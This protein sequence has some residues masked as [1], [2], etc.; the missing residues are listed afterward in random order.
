MKGPDTRSEEFL[1][2]NEELTVRLLDDH[3]EWM[4]S[5]E[6][7]DLEILE[8]KRKERLKAALGKKQSRWK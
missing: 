7:H 4:K 2:Y 1:A 6:Q 8:L 3:N 5:Q